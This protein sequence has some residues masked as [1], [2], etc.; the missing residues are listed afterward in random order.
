MHRTE[1]DGFITDPIGGQNVFADED[2]PARDATQ[3]RYQ[4]ANAYQE[5]IAN[6]IIGAGIALNAS[7]ESIQQMVQLRDAINAL[8]AVESGDRV[9]GDNN[10]QAYTLGQIS[11]VN[12]VIAALTG[13]N[14]GDDSAWATS[15]VRDALNIILSR[16][17][18]LGANEDGV[19]VAMG[20]ALKPIGAPG[21][22]W[23][24]S[25]SWV[26][27]KKSYS[28][29]RVEFWG[30]MY[31]SVGVAGMGHLEMDLPN[32]SSDF[33][34]WGGSSSLG[35]GNV[36]SAWDSAGPKLITIEPLSYSIATLRFVDYRESGGS[37]L[38][39][40]GTLRFGWNWTG[41]FL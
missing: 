10:Q 28:G 1:G 35:G 22:T 36:V 41:H 18:S 39:P 31:G 38:I 34:G 3:L 27:W 40:V 25:G 5:E 24:D 7:S 26:R 15:S 14:I 23:T 9:I 37:H 11:A 33:T 6:V 17:N 2:P 20:P 8:I 12:G 29:K 19:Q 32:L 13:N 21:I 16:I 4:E 30:L